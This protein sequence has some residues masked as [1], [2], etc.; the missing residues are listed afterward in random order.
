[1]FK[2]KIAFM[3]ALTCV[4]VITAFI[5]S[6]FA[7]MSPF[8]FDVSVDLGSRE[9]MGD[10]ILF[11]YYDLRTKAQGGPNLTD[12]YFTVVNTDGNEWVQAHLR[13]RTGQCSIELLDFD[14]IMSPN[15]V[16]TFDLF[17]DDNGNTVFASCDTETLISSGFGVDT[18]GCITIDT[19][20]A[21]ALVLVKECGNC[22][23]GSP[24]SDSAA[25]EATRW[26]YVEIIGEVEMRPD[27][28]ASEGDDCWEG[29]LIAGNYTSWSWV[30][31]GNGCMYSGVGM[32]LFGRVY[33]AALDSDGNVIKVATA[34]GHS[35]PNAVAG[36]NWDAG[37]TTIVHR[38]CYSDTSV[39][40]SSGDGELES[41]T[42]PGYAYG[43]VD[44]T[45]PI[46]GADDM[47]Y[48]YWNDLGDGSG[49]NRVG[50]AAT[51]GPTMAD[52][53]PGWRDNDGTGAP[54]A[55]TTE[56]ILMTQNSAA[57]KRFAVSHY[58]YFSDD[59][60]SRYVFTFPLQHFVNQSITMQKDVRFDTEE[61][62]C[63]ITTGK[64]ISP[65]LPAPGVKVGE[66]AIIPAHDPDDGCS[67]GEGWLAFELNVSS[68]AIGGSD[69]EPL[70]LG[71]V[72]NWG[73]DTA[74]QGIAVSPMQWTTWSPWVERPG[75]Q[76]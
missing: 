63:T 18:E 65:G 13:V 66:V 36:D 32:N 61:N 14:V 76:P 40:C 29:D 7:G 17:Q 28:G 10:Q 70:A 35:S 73:D 19:S 60:Q 68:D 47:N 48:C 21:S 11:S 9:V 15:D 64:F 4:L 34:N 46:L 45:L 31:E 44:A 2:K 49:L 1:M 20:G 54:A 8:P 39:G 62:E 37:L 30:D 59:N 52:F 42:G 12:N 43:P 58:W 24:I 22:P 33:Y 51:F 69:Y 72:A 16:F 27:S 25:L 23:D 3:M 38:P 41:P 67:Y 57:G 5:G 55:T 71:L 75:A 6:A 50:A 56:N 26:G 53:R 74:V